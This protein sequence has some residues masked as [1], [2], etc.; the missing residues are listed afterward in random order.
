MTD[1]SIRLLVIAALVLLASAVTAQNA[2]AKPVL[3]PAPEGVIIH[4]DLPYLEPGREEK[5]DLYLPADRPEGVR[6]PAI[7]FIHGGGWV[8]GDKAETRAFNY[9]T[10]LAKAGYV[11]VSINYTLE[12]GKCW[13]TNVRDC[14]N[15][16]RW[17][18]VN[19]DKYQVDADHIG[20]VGGSAGGHLALMV[21]YT[22]NVPFLEP[23][24]PYPLV[25]NKVQCVVNLYGITNLLTRQK[26]DDDG[27]PTGVTYTTQALM[28]KTRDEDPDAWKL[29]SPVYHV[30]K[31]N[32]PPTLTLHGKADATVDYEQAIELAKKL[33]EHGVEN[34]LLLIEGVGHTFDLQTWRKK[35]LPYDLRP[36]VIGFFDRHLKRN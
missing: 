14:K 6:S 4:P 12:R 36:I 1:H 21:A 35:P 33:D 30:S 28:T 16:V 22:G 24:S 7:V 32:C 25:S 17:L 20:V 9:G 13:P 3:P 31:W 18:R 15:A 34:Q 10:T 23:A 27:N 11:F 8:G 26:T 29:A 2:P 5:L 19:A